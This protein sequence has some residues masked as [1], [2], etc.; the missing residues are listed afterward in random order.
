MRRKLK[1]WFFLFKLHH[2]VPS[3]TFNFLAHLAELSRFINS[4]QKISFSDFY[5]NKF[6]YK[7]RKD[8]FEYIVVEELLDKPIDYLEF[9]VCKGDSIRW[10]VKRLKNKKSKFYGFDTFSG[11]P[12]D[13]GPFK[14]GDMS[15]GNS[16]P[17]I[18]DKRVLFFQGVFQQTL[19]PFLASY[20]NKNRK[21]IH[22]DADLYSST[23]YVL[24][25]ITPYLKPNDIILF[26]EFNVPMHEFK[27][28]YEWSNSFYIKFE[29]IGAVNNF[30]QIGV[31]IK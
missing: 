18:N 15:N 26:D 16:P 30:Y 20:K 14:A 21:V 4:Q 27:A 8:L 11:L 22:L 1:S 10:W 24:T 6:I 23:L 29:I 13:W 9:G 25:L 17:E 31:R 7:K 2:F 12:E 19:V 5:S 3:K 28:F